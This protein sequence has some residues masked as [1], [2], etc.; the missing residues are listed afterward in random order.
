MFPPFDCDADAL[1]AGDATLYVII[2][3]F[4]PLSPFHTVCDGALDT[5]LGCL[6]SSHSKRD[7]YSNER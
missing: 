6:R 2:S 5:L 1:P 3:P 4:I 7:V